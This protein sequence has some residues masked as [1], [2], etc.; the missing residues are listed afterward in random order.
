M[1]GQRAFTLVELMVVV[2]LI[3][4]LSAAIIPQMR[5]TYH[6]ALLRSTSREL[7]NAFHIAYSRAVSLN[8]P[9]RVRV[10]VRA[11][12][13]VVERRVG[14]GA[15]EQFVAAND[16]SGSDG[17]LDSRIRVEFH[18]ADDSAGDTSSSAEPPPIESVM[19]YPDGTAD[20]T[21]VILRDPEGFQLALRVNPVTARVR[22]VE[23]APAGSG[24]AGGG[25]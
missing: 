19:F 15:R 3:G 8:Q 6:D 4:I 14:E 21:D 5:G 7:R 24:I 9:Y 12:R 22:V 13:Y 16:L 1:R 25:P 2:V 20:A 11:S 23:M 10:D 18:S 17:K